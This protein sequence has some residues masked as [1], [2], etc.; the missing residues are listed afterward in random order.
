MTAILQRFSLLAAWS[1]LLLLATPASAQ[2]GYPYGPHMMGWHGGWL[3]MLFAPL[4]IILVLAIVI[5]VAIL[6][7]R[8]LGGP[9]QGAAP[10]P[11]SRTPLDI[12][13]ERFARGEI[14]KEE[15]EE[16]R[17]VLSE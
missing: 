6:L 10:P 7:V 11:P 16:R 13:Q 1:G 17:R 9:W 4:F 8:S 14:D 2:Q 15:Y 12:L 3:G 5:A